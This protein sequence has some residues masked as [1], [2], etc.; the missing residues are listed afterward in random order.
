MKNVPD[1]TIYRTKDGRRVRVVKA[2][3]FPP[4]AVDPVWL[5]EIKEKPP[6]NLTVAEV[7]NGHRWY[8]YKMENLMTEAEWLKNR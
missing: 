2:K 5:K 8:G 1:D 7:K 6:E 3:E 4:N